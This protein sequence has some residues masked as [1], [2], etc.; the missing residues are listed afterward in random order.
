MCWV[1]LNLLRPCFSEQPRGHI[2]TSTFLCAVWAGGGDDEGGKGAAA[3]KGDRRVYQGQDLT[4]T[5][6]MVALDSD[7][8][9]PAQG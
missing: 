2:P 3:Q 6:T 1:H 4:T 5:V 7:A 8:E 9:E